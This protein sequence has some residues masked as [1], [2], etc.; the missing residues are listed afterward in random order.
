MEGVEELHQGAQLAHE[1]G[2]AR[3]FVADDLDDSLIVLPQ[4]HDPAAKVVLEHGNTATH[5]DELFKGDVPLHRSIVLLLFLQ[6][7]NLY[8]FLEGPPTAETLARTLGSGE[9]G[10]E[11]EGRT[12]ICIDRTSWG[13]GPERHAVCRA[14]VG[15]GRPPLEVALGSPGESGTKK[16]RK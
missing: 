11:T 13:R 6:K 7:Q 2:G 9:D 3:G 16:L 14:L 1:S 4:P 10:A 12:C 8:T 15:E 5:G